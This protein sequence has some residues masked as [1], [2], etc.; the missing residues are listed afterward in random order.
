MSSKNQKSATF[1]TLPHHPSAISRALGGFA[2]TKSKTFALVHRFSKIAPKF[3][4][5]LANDLR[6]SQHKSSMTELHLIGGQMRASALQRS[7]FRRQRSS[8]LHRFCLRVSAPRRF[9]ARVPHLYHFY[10]AREYQSESQSH[11]HKLCFPPEKQPSQANHCNP[12]KNDFAH[13]FKTKD[14]K[15]LPPQFLVS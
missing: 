9:N 6:I 4:P 7:I 13:S 11:R 14:R 1:V 12:E 8:I 10:L 15:W 5:L 2:P 3:K